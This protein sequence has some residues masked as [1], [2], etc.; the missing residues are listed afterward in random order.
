[1]KPHREHIV[2]S[3]VF[4]TKIKPHCDLIDPQQNRAIKCYYETA[5]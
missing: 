3:Y 2:P 1:M 4:K 5:K